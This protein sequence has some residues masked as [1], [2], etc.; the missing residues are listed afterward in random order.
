MNETPYEIASLIGATGVGAVTLVGFF[1]E[2]PRERGNCF[3]VKSDDGKYRR[4]LNFGHENFEELLDRGILSYPVEILP[5]TDGH[6]LMAD[7][8]IPKEWY[9]KKFC[10]VCTP[11]NLLPPQQKLERLLDLRSGKRKETEFSIEGGPSGVLVSCQPPTNEF[12]GLQ[13]SR[14]LSDQKTY[15]RTGN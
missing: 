6:C 4:V 10:A 13:C 2:F 11:L 7:H 9:D 3:S 5:L 14:V 1:G 15:M 8:R 12:I